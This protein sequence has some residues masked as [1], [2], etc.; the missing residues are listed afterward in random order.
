MPKLFW[1]IYMNKVNLTSQGDSKAGVS[2]ACSGWAKAA[3]LCSYCCSHHLWFYD[4]GR[5]GR[6]EIATLGVGARAKEGKGGGGGEKKYAC[7]MSLRTLEKG[8]PDW[9]GLGEVNWCLSINCESI[10]FIPFSFAP[11]CGK[12]LFRV[13]K[14]RT[15][16]WIFT[17][18]SK[19][20]FWN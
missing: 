12:E 19:K 20:V 8:A 18:L 13:R 15:E 7:P 16:I 3:C 6:V 11:C 14:W 4:R 10:L 5:L 2:I 17:L 9:G 1:N